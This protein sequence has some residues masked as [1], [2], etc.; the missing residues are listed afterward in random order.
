MYRDVEI[1][2]D[3]TFRAAAREIDDAFQDAMEKQFRTEGS[4]LLGRRWKSLSTEYA[5]RKARKFGKKTIL[6]RTDRLFDSLVTRSHSEHI[7]RIQGP[8]ITMGSKVPYGR[9]HQDG[10]RKK[11]RPPRRQIIKVPGWLLKKWTAILHKHLWK[12]R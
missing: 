6:R 10:G 8:R 4:S 2:T 7:F 3:K 1:Q 9:F 11:G 5:K 12:K